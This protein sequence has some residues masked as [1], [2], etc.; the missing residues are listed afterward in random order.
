[1]VKYNPGLKRE[2]IYRLFSPHK[3][4][5]NNKIPLIS[6]SRLIKIDRDL[7]KRKRIG[8]Y[9]IDNNETTG[10]EILCE[11]DNKGNIFI[12]IK[13]EK[14]VNLSKIEYLIKKNINPILKLIKNEFDTNGHI[15]DLFS[16]FDDK[17]V[18]LLTLNYNSI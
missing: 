18:E 1:M 16:S 8:F 10:A 13:F 14:Y 4:I 6:K 5:N 11:I 7:A 3:D 15:I 12:N 9:I 2:N 17:N